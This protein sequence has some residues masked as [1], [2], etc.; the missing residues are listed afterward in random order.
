MK[1][2]LKLSNYKP[3]GAIVF[4]LLANIS[5]ALT[6]LCVTNVVRADYVPPSSSNP[7]DGNAGSSST[8]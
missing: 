1:Q 3:F 2:R 4:C 8:R 5:F 7:P 6:F